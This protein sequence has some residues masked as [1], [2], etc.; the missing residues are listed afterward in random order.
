MIRSSGKNT[1]MDAAALVV[2]ED[3]SL[4]RLTSAIL[5]QQGFVVREACSMQGAAQTIQEAREPIELFIAHFDA[6]NLETVLE[7]ACRLRA[8]SRSLKLILTSACTPDAVTFEFMGKAG[9]TFL[10]LPYSYSRFDQALSRQPATAHSKV[11]AEER[12]MPPPSLQPGRT[13]RL[14]PVSEIG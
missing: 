14:A 1:T 2:G 4:R 9:I 5:R 13:Q 12:R 8:G 11:H 6:H 3:P 10:S 7:T